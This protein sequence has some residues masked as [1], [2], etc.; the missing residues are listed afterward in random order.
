MRSTARTTDPG[1]GL[2]EGHR[3]VSQQRHL[4]PSASE[5][6]EGGPSGGLRAGVPVTGALFRRLTVSSL[7]SYH[8]GQPQV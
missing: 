5:E 4:V 8:P 2:A 3:R 1:S 7:K 6:I